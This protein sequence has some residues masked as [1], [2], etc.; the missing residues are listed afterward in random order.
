VAWAYAHDSVKFAGG[1]KVEVDEDHADHAKIAGTEAAK[2]V[3]MLELALGLRSERRSR[4]RGETW[5]SASTRTTRSTECPQLHPRNTCIRVR[6][7]CLLYASSLMRADCS[8]LQSM[9]QA[10]NR[11]TLHF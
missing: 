1:V 2:E 11:F 8:C 7:H 5:S 10:L 3:E 9:G 4:G 6:E